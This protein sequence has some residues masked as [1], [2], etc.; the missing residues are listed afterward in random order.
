MQR[1]QIPSH[2]GIVSQTDIYSAHNPRDHSSFL[3]NATRVPFRTWV[4]DRQL[5][6]RGLDNQRLD[7]I[8]DRNA[9]MG[10][11]RGGR[12]LQH[13]VISPQLAW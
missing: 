12:G 2:G 8:P 7:A 3:G 4:E 5:N 11:Q 10:W 13:G 9:W 1:G 6:P